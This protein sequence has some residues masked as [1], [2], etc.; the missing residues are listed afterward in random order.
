MRTAKHLMLV[1]IVAAPALCAGT[2]LAQDCEPSNW[3]SEDVLGAANLVTSERV[4]SALGT[5]RQ[6]NVHPLGIVVGPELPAFPPRQMMLQVVQ[7]GQHH[8]RSLDD[9]Y[10]WPMSYNDDL[11]QLWFGMGPQLDGLGHLGEDGVFYNCNLGSDFAAITGLQTLGIQDV[12]P[13]VGRGV[14][15]DMAEHF[16]V[17]ALAGGQAFGSADIREAAAAQG[18]RFEDGDVILFRFN[19]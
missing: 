14:L 17:D 15:L 11:S 1:S 6:G 4:L 19:V 13:L 5:V 8:G 18:I 16:G 10:G 12:P 7:P 2:A 3:G 9:D